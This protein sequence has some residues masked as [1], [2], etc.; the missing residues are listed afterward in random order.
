MCD[1]HGCPDLFTV[2]ASDYTK[3]DKLEW[4]ASKKENK[5][6]TL[7]TKM[8]NFRAPSEAIDPLWDI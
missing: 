8:V 6:S 1:V 4:E 5:L 7:T 3:F 2:D